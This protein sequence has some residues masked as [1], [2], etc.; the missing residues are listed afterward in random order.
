MKHDEDVRSRPVTGQLP[1]HY[2]YQHI[3]FTKR[4]VNL[5]TNRQ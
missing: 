2:H 3:L 4:E 5:K 1:V